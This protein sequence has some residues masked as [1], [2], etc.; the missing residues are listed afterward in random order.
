M[1][2]TETSLVP[3]SLSQE[4]INSVS[5]TELAFATMRLLPTPDQIPKD[6]YNGNIYT[7]IAESVFY[8]EESPHAEVTFH[9][10]FDSDEAGIKA[11]QKCIMA[12]LRSFGPKHQDK[13]AG[14]GYMI[15]KIMTIQGEDNVEEQSQG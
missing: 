4:D 9:P 8:G 12:H 13:I 3:Y 14:V 2:T 15:S 5:V 1:N 7:R 11:M 10:G 6:F